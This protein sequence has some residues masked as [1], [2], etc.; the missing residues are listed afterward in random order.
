MG[1]ETDDL[2]D[3]A[4]RCRRLAQVVEDERNKRQLLEMAVQL[5]GQA[6]SMERAAAQRKS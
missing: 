6:E 3:H 1:I 5:D 2:R 4:E